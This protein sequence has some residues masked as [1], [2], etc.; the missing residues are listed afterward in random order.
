MSPSSDAT[1]ADAAVDEVDD[2]LVVDAEIRRGDAEIVASFTVAPGTTTALVGPNGA[3]KTTLIEAVAGLVPLAPAGP[4]GSTADSPSIR[5][6]GRVVD[7]PASGVFLPPEQRSVGVVFQDL[8]LFEH[9]DVVGNVAFGR[10]A[11]GAS[12]RDAESVARRWIAAV[13]LEGAADRRP[14][15]LS[16]GQAQRVAL[17]RA[18]AA[19]PA[20]LLFD[21]PLSALDVRTRAEMRRLVRTHLDA[22]AGPRLL[23]THDPSDAFALADRVVVLEAGRVTQSGTPAEIR[24][25]PA[26]AYVAALGGV[27]L[28]WGEARRGSVLVTSHGPRSG[29]AQGLDDDDRPPLELTVLDQEVSGAVRCTIPPRA[30]ALSPSRPRGSQRNVWATTVS[31][32]EPMGD[33]VRI[34]LDGPVRLAADVTPGAVA[35]LTLDAGVEVWAAVK[36]TEIDVEPI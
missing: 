24:Q 8:R 15:E 19:D 21:E 2:G 16:G 10:R 36:A 18:L 5:I 25:R 14:T 34:V 29:S 9:L 32:I 13:G 6:G 7:R 11:R 23:V 1:D 28:V 31:S 3:G 27:N 26:T 22:L 35:A 12:R 20:V 30:I 33:R 17:A 4:S